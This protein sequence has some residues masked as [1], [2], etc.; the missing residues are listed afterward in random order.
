[1]SD[2][3]KKNMGV[4]LGLLLV[5]LGVVVYFNFFAG[6]SGELLS[7]TPGESAVSQEILL[8]LNNLKTIKLDSSFFSD[9]TFLSLTSYGVEL[10][11][12]NVG[13]RNPFEPLR[14]AN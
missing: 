2:L 10:A 11:P 12:E 13:R 4:V 14:T 5:I 3:I 6:K 9:P 1:M 7:A 8:A